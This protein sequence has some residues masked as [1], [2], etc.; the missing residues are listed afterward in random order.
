MAS[1]ILVQSRA[2]A[3]KRGRANEWPLLSTFFDQKVLM[4]A[5]LVQWCVYA[6]LRA[7]VVQKEQLD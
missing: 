5:Q 2:R 1:R 7:L 3:A 4:A 6:A